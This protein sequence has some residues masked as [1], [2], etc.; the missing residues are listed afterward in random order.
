MNLKY[1]LNYDKTNLLKLNDTK[2]TTYN[3]TRSA[4]KVK[5]RKAFTV[6]N[7]YVRK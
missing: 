7:C 3:N 1:F 6:V 4:T 5:I 2:D